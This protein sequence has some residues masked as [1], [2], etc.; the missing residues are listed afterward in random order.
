MCFAIN[1]LPLSFVLLTPIPLHNTSRKVRQFYPNFLFTD[2]LIYKSIPV[3]CIDFSKYSKHLYWILSLNKALMILYLASIFAIESVPSSNRIAAFTMMCLAIIIKA[4]SF[5]SRLKWLFMTL[6]ERSDNMLDML[7]HSWLNQENDC[8]IL[9]E[10]KVIGWKVIHIGKRK[11]RWYVQREG[12]YWWGRE[13][14]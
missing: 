9:C 7:S 4:L 14:A 10:L 2:D 12:G 5:L 1:K 13:Y 6:P 8:I 3:Q 11:Y